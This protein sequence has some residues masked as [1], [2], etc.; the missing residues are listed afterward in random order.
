MKY[1]VEVTE[2]VLRTVYYGIEAD[3]PENAAL[4]AMRGETEWESSQDRDLSCSS[5]IIDRRVDSV[6]ED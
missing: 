5:E 1:M 3:S 2:T 6:D 4:K